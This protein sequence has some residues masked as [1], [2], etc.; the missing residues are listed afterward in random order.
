MFETDN[1]L[2]LVETFL[3][4]FYH[5]QD[6]LAG[7]TRALGALRAEP[8]Y[9]RD[10]AYAFKHLLDHELPVGTLHSLV[11]NAAN[12]DV[13]T[14]EEARDYMRFLYEDNL[15]NFEIDLEDEG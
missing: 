1:A 3:M 12:R 7:T 15:L 4:A 13:E 2:K 8:A 6:D 14:D 11:R 9:R 10:L 5:Q